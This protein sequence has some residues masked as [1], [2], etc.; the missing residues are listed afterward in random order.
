MTVALIIGAI[1][2]LAGAAYFVIPRLKPKRRP[3]TR[4]FSHTFAIS[5][6]AGEKFPDKDSAA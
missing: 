3:P 4:Y 5:D 6:P 2:L 1:V